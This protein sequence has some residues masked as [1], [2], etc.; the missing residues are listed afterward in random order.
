MT[1]FCLVVIPPSLRLTSFGRKTIA[2]KEIFAADPAA[3]KSNIRAS[4]LLS[5]FIL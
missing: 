2:F 1:P 3:M 4:R 5:L